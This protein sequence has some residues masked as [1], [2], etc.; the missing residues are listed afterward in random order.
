M[1]PVQQWN[2]RAACTLQAALRLSNES[3]AEHLGIAARTVAM[4]HQK[5]DRVPQPDVQKML[6]TALTR[7]DEGAQMR[8]TNALPQC[9]TSAGIGQPEG[10]DSLAPGADLTNDPDS[11]TISEE[12]CGGF[13]GG[14]MG[15]WLHVAPSATAPPDGSNI[16]E[17]LRWYRTREGLS[18]QSVAARLNTTQ[19]RLSK[20]EK[21]T[22]VLRDVEELRRLARQLGIPP[23]R[24]G[25]LPDRSS[26]ANPLAAHVSDRPGP[27]RDSQERWREVRRQ[28]NAQRAMLGDLA[29]ELYPRQ[30]RIPGT[31]VLT[32]ADWLPDGPVDLSDITLTWRTTAP[33]P[34]HH[35]QGPG[36][37]MCTPLD[38]QR[39][40]LRPLFPRAARLGPT[41]TVGQSH[42]LSPA[43]RRLDRQQGIGLVQLHNLF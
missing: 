16:G 38:G 20:L 6:D 13:D 43:R 12:E 7:A 28:L 11:A 33:V 23:E 22:Q 4:W 3:F 29:A 1:E 2:G 41:A 19:S 40:T 36:I 42:Q 39:K 5:P 15:G 18:Q 10:G 9:D 31:T 24:L 35:R 37:R 21:G 30:E 14:S 27:G 26:D 8:F 34:A 17:I 32:C 25:V